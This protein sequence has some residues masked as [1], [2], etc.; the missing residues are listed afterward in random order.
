M[1]HPLTMDEKLP[2][3]NHDAFRS[4]LVF[5][6][7]R[8]DGTVG[9]YA[10]QSIELLKELRAQGVDA[11]WS[12]N[13]EARGWYGERSA[14]VELIVIPLIV[15][16]ASSA[17]W[18]VLKAVFS[19]KEKTTFKIKI[20]ARVHPDGSQDSQFEI[21]GPGSE[22]SSALEQLNPWRQQTTNSDDN[23]DLGE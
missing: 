14:V 18:G 8:M 10:E 11:S 4:E 21:E 5:F 22:I 20:L 1:E 2:Y 23:H 17:A 16:V 15:G 13:R 6:P 9:I 7:I 3:P 12:L 19:K